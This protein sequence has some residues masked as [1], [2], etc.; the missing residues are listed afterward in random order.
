MLCIRVEIHIIKNNEKKMTKYSHAE[1]STIWNKATIV[2]GQDKNIFRK[3]VCGAWIAWKEH[4]NRNSQY[5]WEVDHIVPL[6]RNG[7]HHID[8]VHP[9][10]WQNNARKS[11]GSFICA[12]WAK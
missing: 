5:G 2:P 8:N 11:D 9:L 3:D 4:G 6:S 12:V 7:A 10:H 1:L